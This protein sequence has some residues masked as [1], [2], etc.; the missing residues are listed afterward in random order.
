MPKSGS[1]E[2]ETKTYHYFL[3]PFLILAVR[4]R[5]WR[6]R[7][8]VWRRKS[9]G[10]GG[11]NTQRRGEEVNVVLRWLGNNEAFRID[12]VP[13]PGRDARSLSYDLE[14]REDR[15]L[16]SPT[17][18]PT[19][20]ELAEKQS[21]LGSVSS[22]K[23]SSVSSIA[24]LVQRGTPD[25]RIFPVDDFSNPCASKHNS[26]G[27]VKRERLGLKSEPSPSTMWSSSRS[28]PVATSPGPLIPE[29]VSRT[30]HN[31]SHVNNRDSRGGEKHTSS[32]ARWKRRSSTSYSPPHPTPPER[33]PGSTPTPK[34][35]VKKRP[36]YFRSVSSNLSP[37]T[38]V[39]DNTGTVASEGSTTRKGHVDPPV[40]A[41]L[42]YLPAT[43]LDAP[44]SAQKHKRWS[45][46]GRRWCGPLSADASGPEVV[47]R[48]PMPSPRAKPTYQVLY[49]AALLLHGLE[50]RIF[51]RK[52]KSVSSNA[53]KP[54]V[55]GGRKHTGKSGPTNAEDGEGL[56]TLL[57]SNS[58]QLSYASE[59]P[60]N[61]PYPDALRLGLDSKGH[62]RQHGA[63][64][65][66]ATEMRRVN[67]PPML[68]DRP[69][70]KNKA[71]GFFFDYEA[72]D[73][74]EQPKDRDS[75]RTTPHHLSSALDEGDTVPVA[76]FG[77]SNDWFRV[78]MDEI[79]NDDDDLDG[80]HDV[81]FVLDVPDHLPNSPLCPLSPKHKSG[82]KAVCPSHGRKRTIDPASRPRREFQAFMQGGP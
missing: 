49:E 73:E 66:L 67:T 47:G 12:S 32:K 74:A 52:E 35:D 18:L 70:R 54:S 38:E 26:S 64:T 11:N 81:P 48:V 55:P 21:S 33:E 30:P 63:S 57:R 78:R 45:F 75:A 50:P 5:S 71:R 16:S 20:G 44:E 43:P 6:K 7:S 41:P 29:S 51:R 19:W 39:D 72:P 56:P 14:V 34:G 53:F 9:N 68:G 69:A 10:I 77:S 27:K 40:D 1:S 28:S 37:R 46:R 59:S 61:T 22:T 15:P 82:G 36:C 79:L 4:E 2:S 58:H 3:M 65:Y 60:T 24:R 80:D 62:F 13:K 76:G 17:P 31:G 42:Y 8:I 23:A 25:F